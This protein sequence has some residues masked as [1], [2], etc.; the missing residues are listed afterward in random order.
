MTDPSRPPLAL[1]VAAP[2]AAAR[3]PPAPRT[4]R[5]RVLAVLGGDIGYFSMFVFNACCRAAARS[6]LLVIWDEE[7]Q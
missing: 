4:A 2:R 6:V 3:W 7:R 1:P 5:S